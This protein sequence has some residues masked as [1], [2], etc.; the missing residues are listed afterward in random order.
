MTSSPPTNN[1]PDTP[2]CWLAARNA[3]ARFG[4]LNFQ[5]A[6]TQTA[7]NKLPV[8][9]KTAARSLA[10][11]PTYSVATA[12]PQIPQPSSNAQ[13]PIAHADPPLNY[14]SRFRALVLFG[15]R[16]IERA[17]GFAITGVQK[18]TQFRTHAPHQR[19]AGAG[20]LNHLVDE[21]EERRRHVEAKCLGRLE[22]D[23]QF[24]LG[25]LK[26]RY[27]SRL[28]ALQDAAGIDTRLAKHVGYACAIA[29]QAAGHGKFAD[30]RPWWAA[31]SVQLVR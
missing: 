24:E 6:A 15:R 27:V 28:L 3:Q 17:T 23:D 7:P 19:R 2:S 22:I 12:S 26:H 14:L 9:A 1:H 11:A 30:Q 25:G 31:N 21:R 16:P 13:I 29:D 18:P 5:S 8:P 4:P 10:D 20:L